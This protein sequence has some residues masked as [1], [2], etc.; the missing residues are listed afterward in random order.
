MMWLCRKFCRRGRVTKEDLDQRAAMP[1]RVREASHRLS[2]A[3]MELEGSARKLH[4]EADIFLDLVKTM[5]G[6]YYNSGK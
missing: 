6:Q 1:T 4:R 3:A 5:S 2:N